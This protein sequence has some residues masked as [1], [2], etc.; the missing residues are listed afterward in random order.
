MFVQQMV[1]RGLW[2]QKGHDHT[3]DVISLGTSSC[4]RFLQ[5]TFVLSVS[6][7]HLQVSLESLITI[8]LLGHG[9]CKQEKE[10]TTAD[11]ARTKARVKEALH[12]VDVR[13]TELYC[14]RP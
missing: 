7:L 3:V 6:M 2:Q 9:V 14:F 10:K 5:C 11:Q 1:K 12:N 8:A 4:R 13:R